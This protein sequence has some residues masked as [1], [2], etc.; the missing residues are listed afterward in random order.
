MRRHRWL[1]GSLLVALVVCGVAC[2]G[3]REEPTIVIRFEPSDADVPRVTRPSP[4]PTPTPTPAPDASLGKKS[5]KKECK[6][7]ADCVVMQEECCNCAN[8]GKQQA[9]PKARQASVKAALQAKC[10][11][12]VCTMMM[13]TDPTCGMKAD[14]VAG[15]CSLVEK[16]K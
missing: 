7:A 3:C 14:C 5:A 11:A 1:L 4:T 16:K 9:V 2:N 6:A 13:S 8:G 12:A 15:I 10:K